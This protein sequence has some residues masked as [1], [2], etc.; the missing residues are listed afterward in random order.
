[1]PPVGILLVIALIGLLILLLSGNS[2]PGAP[3]AAPGPPVPSPPVPVPPVAPVPPVPVPPVPV[4][5]VPPVPVPPVP[6]A[7]GDH[8]LSIFS[9]DPSDYDFHPAGRLATAKPSV[10]DYFMIIGDWGDTPGSWPD[11]AGFHPGCQQQIGQHMQDYQKSAKKSTPPLFV[12]SVGDNFYGAGNPSWQLWYQVYG[13]LTKLP[14][15]VALG[16]HDYGAG[17][18]CY[19][20]PESAQC[21]GSSRWCSIANAG[22]DYWKEAKRC[23]TCTPGSKHCQ[24]YQGKQLSAHMMP[25]DKR[26]IPDE[27][28]KN[29]HCPDKNFFMLFP[30]QD[31]VV[32]VI[33]VDT[34]AEDIGGWGGRD[35]EHQQHCS[36][37]SEATARTGAIRSSAKAMVQAR[38]AANRA[39]FIIIAQHYP[40][41]NAPL[42]QIF[43]AALP[44]E[45]RNH[46][47]VIAAAGHVHK[48]NCQNGLGGD[49]R[50]CVEIT[51]GGGGGCCPGDYDVNSAGFT[52]V[53]LTKLNPPEFK[54]S[55]LEG[56]DIDFMRPQAGC[57]NQSLHN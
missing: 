1:M 10:G 8:Y 2:P 35:G 6:P 34:N 50:K 55:G 19:L 30:Q 42:R 49:A 54:I 40:W 41:M 3:P 9:S 57:R 46:V 28:V 20:C 17:N 4:P 44:P 27:N 5:P 16:N 33:V 11:N 26:G 12:V 24:A 53:E 14:W 56:T 47:Q 51:T 29:W 18:P 21:R 43:L 32:E 13:P 36:S 48:Q 22:N 38:G 39:P 23:E 45:R 31:P 37:V 52:V 15:L 7:P 25:D